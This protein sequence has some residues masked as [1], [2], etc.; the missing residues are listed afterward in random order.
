MMVV[1]IIFFAGVISTILYLAI[2]ITQK[3]DKQMKKAGAIA[4]RR[5]ENQQ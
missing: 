4:K 3:A 5:R 1:F 2:Y